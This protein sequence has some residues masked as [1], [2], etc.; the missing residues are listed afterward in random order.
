MHLPLHE[1]SR[2]R[3]A[4][5]FQSLVHFLGAPQRFLYVVA[6]ILFAHHLGELCFMN[7][8]RRLLARPTQNQRPLAGLQFLGDLLD[9]EQSSRIE[10]RIFLN[11]KITTGGSVCKS[12]VT[13]EI[14]SVPPNR[15]GP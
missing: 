8:L 4:L 5:C 7:Q 14:L 3:R 15:K 11:R 6:N 10:G 9:R 12:S 1:L 2:S 13:A